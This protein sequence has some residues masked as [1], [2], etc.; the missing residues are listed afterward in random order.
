[1][2]EQNFSYAVF[3]VAGVVASWLVAYS[4]G[5]ACTWLTRR[6]VGVVTCLYVLWLS[7]D[8]LAI[9]LDVF[10][11]PAEGSLPIRVLGIPLE[12]HLFFVVHAVTIWTLI[13]IAESAK[14]IEDDHA[15]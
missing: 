8:M 10:R 1:M 12:E 15:L 2:T 13:L 11:F 9:Q 7:W 6:F 4:L 3:E 14:P 5:A